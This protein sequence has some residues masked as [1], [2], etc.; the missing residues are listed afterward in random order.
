MDWCDV[1]HLVP[2][3]L[4]PTNLDNLVPLCRRHHVMAH[5]GGWTLRRDVETRELV[6]Q[7]P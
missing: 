2:Y 7:P 3:P 4:G 5:E 1:H 6:A